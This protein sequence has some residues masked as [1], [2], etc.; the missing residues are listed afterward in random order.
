MSGAAGPPPR[1][2]TSTAAQERMVDELL[3]WGA[4]RPVTPAGLVDAL[5]AR[6]SGAVAEWSELRAR[7]VP[8]TERPLLV[9]KSRLTRI[10]CDG[11]QREPVPYQHAWANARG[12][13]THAAIELD[14][15]GLRSTSS[16]EVAARAWQRLATDRVGDPASLAA[17]LNGRDE[18]ERS[19]L[20]AESAALLDGFREVW[21]VL[22][23][24]AVRVHTERRLVADL[25]GRAIRLQGVPDLLVTS[26]RRDGHARTLLIDLKTGMPRG[27]QDR[28]ELRF[29]ALLATLRD[30]SPPFRWATLYVTEGRVEHEDLSEAVLAVAA[31][32]VADAIRQAARIVRV[33]QGEAEEHLVGGAWCSRC[34]RESACPVAG[35]RYGADGET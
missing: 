27:Q 7:T 31:E 33:T 30:G 13:L 11:L 10:T 29:Y 35:A 3:A 14:V 24:S 2:F 15:D 16:T 6:L 23:T 34:R 21:P 12:T 8:G 1:P 32:R 20:V 18:A 26:P 19:L 5:M 22:D 28:D 9:T 25:G 4:P 17:W